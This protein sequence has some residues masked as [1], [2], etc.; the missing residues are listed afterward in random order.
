MSRRKGKGEIKESGNF[1]TQLSP[2]YLTL[3]R[4]EIS[5]KCT[6]QFPRQAPEL[7]W[8]QIRCNLRAKKKMRSKEIAQGNSNRGNAQSNGKH[9]ASPKSSSSN[10]GDAPTGF[11]S[12]AASWIITET[13]RITCSAIT[14]YFS[15]SQGEMKA[16]LWLITPIQSETEN[17]ES[18]VRMVAR[19][20]NSSTSPA[21]ISS[22]NYLLVRDAP[23][24]DSLCM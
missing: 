15:H 23:S 2:S 20:Y 1:H 6:A 13:K 4:T 22:R 8:V 16:R 19:M 11:L 18:R 3:S 10:M 9:S 5:W 7:C 21:M 24:A 12:L 17:I 14:A